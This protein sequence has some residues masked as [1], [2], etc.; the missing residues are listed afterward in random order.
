M[1]DEADQL[2]SALDIMNEG[3]TR[4]EVEADRERLFAGELFDEAAPEGESDDEEAMY[5]GEGARQIYLAPKIGGAGEENERRSAKTLRS[6]P[7]PRKRAE[8]L[9][10]LGYP[11]VSDDEMEVLGSVMPP[12]TT[13]P[14]ED[15][16]PTKLRIVFRDQFD[17]VELDANGYVIDKGDEDFKPSK[18]WTGRRAGF[19][20]KLG[21]RGLGYYRTGKKVVVPSNT[22]Y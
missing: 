15:A 5:M 1:N 21:A 19:E 6:L 10:Q 3:K 22:A 4:E 11:V 14:L 20:F 18:T 13:A 16:P 7:I 17:V 12:W 2:E 9:R 8:L